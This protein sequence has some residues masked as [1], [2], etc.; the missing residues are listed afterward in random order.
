M[1][2]NSSPFLLLAA[3][4]P[5]RVFAHVTMTNFYI[6]GQPVLP[7]KCVRMSNNIPQATFPLPV[8]SITTSDIAC[9]VNGQTGVDRVCGVN[10]GSSLTFNF[11]DWP[12]GSQPG[13]IDKSHKGPCAVYMKKVD[14]ASASNNAAGDG[15][16]KIFQHDYDATE[17]KWCTEKIIDNNGLMAVVLPKG[18][19][20]GNYLVRTELLALHQADKTPPDPQFYVGCAQTFVNSSGTALPPDT[21]SIPGYISMTNNQAAMTFNIWNEHMALPYPMFGP[22]VYNGTASKRSLNTRT[23]QTQQSTGLTPE[24]CIIENGNWCGTEAPQYSTEAGCWSSS[25]ECWNQTKACYNSA[26]PTGSANCKIYETHCQDVQNACKANNFNGPP[27]ARKVLTPA[28][29]TPSLPAPLSIEDSSSSGS[30]SSPSPS[31]SPASAPEAATA[32]APSQSTTGSIDQCGSHN[33]SAICATG[34]CCSAHGYCGMSEDYC[35][36]GCQAGFG[37]CSSVVKKRVHLRRHVKD[38]LHIKY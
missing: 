27:S 8:S 18:I 33:A 34:L 3:T 30:G 1:K 16:F 7:G 23:S 29:P 15:W 26:G 5:A 31:T 11:R 21:V 14:D 19:Q 20:G 9:G 37:T 6:D 35:G 17:A 38:L 24:N 36:S 10:D 12:D 13:T 32:P 25:T 2:L 4:L 28:L 22:P